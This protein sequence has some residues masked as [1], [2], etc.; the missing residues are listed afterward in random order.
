MST[1]EAAAGGVAARIAPL[2]ALQEAEGVVRQYFAPT[3]LVAAP[4]LSVLAGRDVFL[5]LENTTPL[6]TFKIRGAL[7]KLAAL[8]RA[9]VDGGVATA[10]AGNHGMAV[11]YAAAAFGRPATIFVP[12]GAN[13]QKVA[14]IKRCGGRVVTGGADYQAAYERC[15]AYASEHGLTIVHAFDDPAVIAG[16]GTVGLELTRQL[17]Q[18]GVTE[19]VAVYVG[20]GGGGL[21][22][23][24]G[25]ALGVLRPE[26]TVVGVCPAR[27][28]ALARSV[29]AG[30]L[31]EVDRVETFADG[32]SARRPGPNTL[33]LAQAYVRQFVRVDDEEIWAAM[34]LLLRLEGIVAEPAGAAAVAALLRERSP[35]GPAVVVV[36][37]AN[38]A[39]AVLQELARR[40]AE[41]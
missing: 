17:P 11:A 15:T 4:G 22:G 5:K 31:V 39:D 9:G 6:R 24:I 23:G 25:A 35:G 38:I 10:S 26:D 18:A 19:P 20:I 33:A 30:E 36:S 29:E 12:D 2:T 7:N 13:P 21:I 14:A 16:Q 32:L 1:N 27:A 37:G 41:S 3:P 40:V 28:D 8:Q 34:A